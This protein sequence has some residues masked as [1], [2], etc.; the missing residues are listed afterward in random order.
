MRHKRVY[1]VM[2]NGLQGAVKPSLKGFCWML[3]LRRP[4]SGP[5]DMHSPLCCMMAS[6]RPKIG[7]VR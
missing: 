7:A 5:A 3:T 2:A 6:G 1:R 4:S